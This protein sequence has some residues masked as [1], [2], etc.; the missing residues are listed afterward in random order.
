M[1]KLAL[2]FMIGHSGHVLI[3]FPLVGIGMYGLSWQGAGLV[4]Q[5]QSM[6]C[7]SGGQGKALLL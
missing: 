7:V 1:M 3:N 4:K 2:F 6:N 5:G